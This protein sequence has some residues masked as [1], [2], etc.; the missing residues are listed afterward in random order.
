MPMPQGAVTPK[1]EPKPDLSAIFDSI[2]MRVKALPRIP[3]TEPEVK[4]NFGGLSDGEL[5]NAE[6]FSSG[7]RPK[8]LA[9]IVF[10]KMLRING[11]L[12]LRDIKNGSFLQYRFNY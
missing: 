12:S 3:L 4:I 1:E 10:E 8:I 2:M 5:M 6:W 7:K 9:K 11:T